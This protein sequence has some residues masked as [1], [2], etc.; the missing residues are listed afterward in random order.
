[1]PAIE[2]SASPQRQGNQLNVEGRLAAGLD[3]AFIAELNVYS[4][5]KGRTPSVYVFNPFAEGRLARGRSFTPVR[6]RR[7]SRATSKTCRS[8]FAGRMTS[9][10]WRNAVGGVPQRHQASGFALPEFVELNAP[11]SLT[12]RKLGSLRPWAWGPDA[13]ELFEPLFANVTGEERTAEQRFN[14]TIAQLYSKFGAPRSSR[15]FGNAVRD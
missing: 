11:L 6:H 15:R 12:R 4:Q 8:S 1:M 3:P 2:V 5:S 13:I 9:C 7:C 14:E 10:W